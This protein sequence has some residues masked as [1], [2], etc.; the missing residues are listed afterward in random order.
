MDKDTKSRINRRKIAYVYLMHRMFEG[1]PAKMLNI[2]N[3]RGV[4]LEDI[5][6]WDLDYKDAVLATIQEEDAH[7]VELKD[8][9]RPVPSIKSIKEKILRR[10]DVLTN[11]TD[12]PARLAQ[13]YKILSEFEGA[14]E[15][16]EKGVLD[17]INDSIKPLTP[18]QKEKTLLERMRQEA[19]LPAREARAANREKAKSA[20]RGPGRPKKDAAD[21][22]LSKLLADMPEQEDEVPEW[23]QDG[24]GNDNQQE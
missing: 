16:K 8:Q 11:M 20:K 18:K 1:S 22:N 17:A 4:K 5:Q 14:D 21:D 19:V 15:K 12:D 3:L 7:G 9:D 2:M 23:L 10:C 13:V 24:D 6:D